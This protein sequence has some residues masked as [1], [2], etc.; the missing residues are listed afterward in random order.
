[1]LAALLPIRDPRDRV[2][3]YELST[4]PLLGTRGIASSEED[5]SDTLE[6]LSTLPLPRLTGG[7]PVHVPVTPMLVR[8]GAL[9]RHASVDAVFVIATQALEDEE[10]RHAIEKLVAKGFRFG[11][12]GF[13]EG[14][15]L[16]DALKGVTVSIDASRITA[17][18]L[19]SRIQQLLHAGVKPLARGVDDR[20]TRERVIALGVPFFSGRLL[21]R[22][23]VRRNDSE[24]GAKRAMTMMIAFSDGRPPDNTFEVFVRNDQRLSSEVLHIF[25]S[26]SM[27]VRGPR[28][29]E[30]AF[31]VIGRE[32]I[33][34]MMTGFVA[35]LAAESAGDIEIALIALRRARMCER[36]ANSFDRAPH[37]RVRL[38]AGLASTLDS[39]FGVPA[40]SLGGHI[41]LSKA[42]SDVV[43]ER[44]QPLG[45]LIDLIEAYDNGWWPDV[46]A[47]CRLLGLSPIL[48]RQSYFDAWRDARDE[49]GAAKP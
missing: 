21:P 38:L 31:N 48:V 45:Q 37:P 25:R 3:A 7:R 43:V 17:L 34:N 46:Y 16:P 29:L 44:E 27:G 18:T 49:L 23:A 10:T 13:P 2:V 6:L 12:D 32:A 36:L 8:E 40:T 26:A 24:A 47:R 9:A 19:A 20:S 5:A 35:R 22:G 11:L 1:M 28:T 14:D 41:A 39:A 30:H 15:P 33:L 42:L 4:Y